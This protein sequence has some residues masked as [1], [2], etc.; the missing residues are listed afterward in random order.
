MRLTI[1]LIITATLQVSAGSYAQKITLRI[2]NTPLKEVFGIIKQQTGYSFFWDQELIDKMPRVNVNVK[3]VPIETALNACLDNSSLTYSI[4]GKIIYL[5]EKPKPS[6]A[7]VIPIQPAIVKQEEIH[8]R[9]TDSAGSPLAGTSVSIRGKQVGTTTDATGSFIINANPEDYLVFSRVGMVTQ[10]VQVGNQRAVNIILR[11]EEVKA[12][13]EV[14]AVAYGK[15]KKITVTGAISTITTQDLRQSPVANLANALAGR[16]PGL[17]AIQMSGE[18]GGD[19]SN[20]YVRGTPTF[21]NASP[22]IVVDG[23][24]GRDFA[25]L[26][27]NEVASVSIL[28]DASATALYGVRGAN[29]VIL[30]T[31]RRGTIGKPSISFRAERAWQST[32]RLPKY[33]NS[34]DYARLYNEA[35][36]NDN[37]PPRFSEDDLEYYK[38][39]ADPYLYP[40]TDW[41]GTV[42][43]KSSPMFRANLNISGGNDRVKYFVSAGALTQDGMYN[44]SDLNPYSSNVKFNRY[45][46]R[47]NIDINVTDHFTIGLDLAGRVE[48]RNYP[49]RDSWLI[50]EMLNMFPPNIPL[51]NADGSLAG[52]PSNVDNPLGLIAYSGFRNYYATMLQGTYKMAHKLDFITPGLSARASFSFDGQS[53]YD[54]SRVRGFAVYQ[55]RDD[56][57]YN[58][59]GA[60]TELGT[61]KEFGYN[62]MVN[63]EGALDYAR[64]FGNHD[65]TG[66]LMYNQ[67]KKVTHDAPYDLPYAY[68]GAASRLTYAYQQK[69]F[70]EINMGYNGSEQFPAK[71][72]F[73]FFPAFSLGWTISKEGFYGTGNFVNYLKMRASYGE[74]GNDQLGN[75]RFLYMQTFNGATGYDFNQGSYPGIAEGALANPDVRWERARKVNL[76]I[77]AGALNNR[78]YLT[79]DVFYEKRDNILTTSGLIPFTLGRSGSDLPPVNIGVVENK[80][81]DFELSY[82]NAPRHRFHYEF[83]GNFTYATNRVLYMAEEPKEEA[84]QMQTGKRVGQVFGLEYIGFYQ[85]QED[86]DNS[87]I[88]TFVSKSSLRPGDLKFR[89]VNGDGFI[90][91]RDQ[92]A[93]GYNPNAPEIMFGFQT[94]LSYK[95]FDLSFLFQGAAHG[96]VFLDNFPVWEFRGGNGKAVEW[97][98]NR[99]TPETA[100]TATYP[101]LYVGDNHNNQSLNS[102]WMR[103]RDYLRLKNFEIGYNFSGGIV[104]RAGMSSLRLYCNGSNLIT[105]DKVKLTDPENPSWSGNHTYPQQRVINVGI[106]TNF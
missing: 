64:S 105:W 93:L 39:G 27:A 106:N 92:I 23:V 84:Y 74:A 37:L 60:E 91:Y 40:N 31:T 4:Q 54:F 7:P 30:V 52:T 75:R 8:G 89:D 11:Y 69:Y 95:G 62:R 100:N 49:G 22:L 63:I 101:R 78:L 97:H 56:G 67:N 80:G 33:V 82:K 81:L 2:Q 25:Q 35:L 24:L 5:K 46:F 26:D 70:A 47:S 83:S 88:P 57:G 9:V 55:L 72:R 34:Y 58:T 42:L 98:L 17:I 102:F 104:K 76:G 15:Q 90:D 66:L 87:P 99:W 53:L 3:N 73:G 16:L 6:K 10:E 1:L 45:N 51:T 19:A 43:K 36:A 77:D 61:Q 32:I 65:V 59:I 94:R 28:K 79:G 48:N 44:F 21:N 85:S 96:T 38:I 86:I 13:E 50:F 41:L 71:N 20:L 103:S 14:V 12:E 29:G 18:P 68:M